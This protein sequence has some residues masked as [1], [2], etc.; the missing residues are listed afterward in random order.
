MRA[1]HTFSIRQQQARAV[2]PGVAFFLPARAASGFTAF[3]Y[4]F[5]L[6]WCV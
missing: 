2:V 3:P 4:G 5:C 1:G 6:Q